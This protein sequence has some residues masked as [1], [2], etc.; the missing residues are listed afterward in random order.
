MYNWKVAAY[1][2]LSKEE[3]YG[4]KN[5]NS[6]SNQKQIINS[7]IKENNDLKLVD[8]YIDDGYSGTD[9]NRPGFKKLLVDIK[10]K[11]VNTVIVKD[12]S[13]LGRNHIEVDNYLENIFPMMNVRFIS[14]IEN[15]DSYE[16][17]E[18]LDN[19]IVPI[20][21]L[22]NDAYAKDI[23]KKI[24]TVLTTKKVNG[25]F[26]GSFAPYGYKKSPDNNH[27]FIK[28]METSYYVLLIF[29]SILKGE[30]SGEIANELNKRKILTPAMHIREKVLGKGSDDINEKWNAK[31]INRILRNRTYTG[32]L[33]QGKKKVESYRNHKLIDTNE[34]DWIIT[35]NHHEPI[36]SEEKFNKV[37][38]I[39][40]NNNARINKDGKVDLFYG[41][42]KCGDCGSKFKKSGEYYYCESYARYKKC[43]K[44]S[45]NRN[46]LISKVEENIKIQNKNIKKLDRKVLF[47][48]IDNI[49]IFDNGNIKINYK[50]K[51]REINE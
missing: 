28:D 47:Q 1:L 33:I 41:Y 21:N 51:G 48:L 5:S 42:L 34:E 31:M 22:M 20:K 8:Y 17:P 30:T 16:N 32:D 23:S 36:I 15:I 43:T 38:E 24:K 40:E 39:I 14:I 6:I 25:E 29:N 26:V 18:S 13:R 3:F 46:K 37:Q 11:K 27:K 10:E 2:R 9:F 7:Y 35:K 12:L 50:E 44:H 19:Y 49:I 45:V 4:D